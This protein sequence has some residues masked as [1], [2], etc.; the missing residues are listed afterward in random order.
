MQYSL[1]VFL[2]HHRY[3]ITIQSY[4]VLFSLTNTTSYMFSYY[5]VIYPFI[6]FEKSRF[7]GRS[8]P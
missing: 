2:E 3:L 8:P 5:P 6:V 7:E 4:N 1:L